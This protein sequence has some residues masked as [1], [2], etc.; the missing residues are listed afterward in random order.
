MGTFGL[1]NY[2]HMPVS[3][4]CCGATAEQEHIHCGK[5]VDAGGC[6]VWEFFPMFPV[7]YDFPPER[8]SLDWA[9]PAKMTVQEEMM[10][11]H[12]LEGV[13]AT[14]R[15]LCQPNAPGFPPS[16]H[17][18]EALGVDAPP[19]GAGR[20]TARA[21]RLFRTASRSGGRFCAAANQQGDMPC[22]FD[23]VKRQRALAQQRGHGRVERL[24]LG[25]R[26][27]LWDVVMAYKPM[28][29]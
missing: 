29:F 24:A 5:C 21:S 28:S 14:V 20:G 10:S 8:H 9:P 2:K 25:Q 6:N 3:V 11:E 27:P 1:P 26:R 16:W 17:E 7:D 22:F 13:A 12:T 15:L 23:V 19:R 18:F 4:D